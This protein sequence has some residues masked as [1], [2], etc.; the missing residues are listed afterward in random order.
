[1]HW[2]YNFI[3]CIGLFMSFTLVDSIVVNTSFSKSVIGQV[4][5]SSIE[6]QKRQVN[7]QKS[8]ITVSLRRLIVSLE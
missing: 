6:L 8:L 2:F 4:E 3:L 5:K 1:M 7:L